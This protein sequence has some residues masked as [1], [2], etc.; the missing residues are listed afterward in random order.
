MY[1][2]HIQPPDNRIPLVKLVEVRLR[3]RKVKR[4]KRRVRPVHKPRRQPV[5]LPYYH[6]FPDRVRKRRV[7]DT[8]VFAEITENARFKLLV[9][10]LAVQSQTRCE[11]KARVRH[12][13]IKI[14]APYTLY[15]GIVLLLGYELHYPVNAVNI[16]GLYHFPSLQNIIYQI[17]LYHNCRKSQAY[18][19]LPADRFRGELSV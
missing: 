3:V 12:A 8:G 19:K 15:L 14:R 11:L 10:L 9:K 6:L 17:I 5:M 13:A 1:R 2:L 18:K 7:V 4:Y 16:Y